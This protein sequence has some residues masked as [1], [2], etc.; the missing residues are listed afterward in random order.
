MT[1]F[2]IIH[3]NVWD[4]LWAVPVVML[5]TEIMKKL[6]PIQPQYVSTIATIIGLLISIFISH[7]HNLAGGIFMGFFY[8]GAAIGSYASLKTSLRAYRNRP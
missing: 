3:T 5:I 4:S 6:L 8:S 7:P 2:P 1:E